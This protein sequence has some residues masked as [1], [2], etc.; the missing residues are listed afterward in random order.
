MEINCTTKDN[1]RAIVKRECEFGW[2]NMN[3]G[4]KKKGQIFKILHKPGN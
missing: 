3:H 4:R 2:L 1:K